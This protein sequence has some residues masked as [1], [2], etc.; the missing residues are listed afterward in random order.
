MERF[1]LLLFLVVLMGAGAFIVTAQD[2]VSSQPITLDNTSSV[3]QLG[4]LDAGDVAVLSIAISPDGRYLLSGHADGV[5]TEWDL[6]TGESK[7]FVSPGASWVYSAIYSPDGTHIAS[8]DK[9]NII[10]WDAVS[11]EQTIVLEG[12]T[13]TA[14]GLAFSSDGSILASTSWDNTIRLWSIVSGKEIQRID[15]SAGI[16]SIAFMPDG[17]TLASTDGNSTGLQLWD[18]ATG[19]ALESLSHT[20]TYY[21]E[22][23]ISSDGTRLAATDAIEDQIY[24]WDLEAQEI[25][26]TIQSHEGGTLAVNFNKLGDVLASVGEDGTLRFWDVERGSGFSPLSS[27]ALVPNRIA[28][29]TD[30][31]LVATGSMDGLI[32]IWGLAEVGE[33]PLPTPEQFSPLQGHW[34]GNSNSIEISFDVSSE[35]TL[36]NFHWKYTQGTSYCAVD[37]TNSIHLTDN[38]FRLGDSEFYIQGHFRSPTTLFGV[39]PATLYCGD[40]IFF[41]TGGRR[42]WW[43]R[44]VSD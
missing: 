9:N 41:T 33:L 17:K 13:E 22:I 1:S 27:N 6:T 15:M 25:I 44:R 38:S 8:V 2:S 42:T 34:E 12:H 30:G 35:G 37:P 7:S 40:M 43:V 18:V 23:A 31:G 26:Q 10:L 28:F 32:Q 39:A 36:L 16:N 29:S 14:E 3:I 5:I 24:I 20:D 19:D 11:K 21:E 4:V